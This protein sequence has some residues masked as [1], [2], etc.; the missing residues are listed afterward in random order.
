MLLFFAQRTKMERRGRERKKRRKAA[1]VSHI[2]L[3]TSPKERK[4]ER[5]SNRWAAQVCTYTDGQR[6][7]VR[8]RRRRHWSVQDPATRNTRCLL[9]PPPGSSRPPVLWPQAQNGR[10]GRRRAIDHLEDG[11]RAVH[12]REGGRGRGREMPN[13]PRN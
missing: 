10:R 13:G 6:D 12:G 2:S 4:Q 8:K 1:A 3:S 9:P 7:N 11:R 5:T